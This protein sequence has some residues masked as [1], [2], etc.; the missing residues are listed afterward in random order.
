MSNVGINKSSVFAIR[1]EVTAGTLIAPSA[2][3]QFVPLKD[4]YEM[5]FEV[6]TLDNE[7][8]LNDIGKGKSFAGL[9][10]VTGT[11]EAYAKNSGVVATAPQL[12]LLYESV[13]GGESSR[14]SRI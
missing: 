12:G 7:E 10:S 9:E 4:G 3:S 6:K 2:G 13:L 14:S 5:N 8:L 1:E 11:H